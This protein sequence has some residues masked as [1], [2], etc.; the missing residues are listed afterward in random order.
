[1]LGGTRFCLGTTSGRAAL[2]R[3]LS[4]SIATASRSRRLETVGLA[5]DY[6]H[7][8]LNKGQLLRI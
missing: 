6:G 8:Y 5:A 2:S 7:L 1:M 4:T 3:Y